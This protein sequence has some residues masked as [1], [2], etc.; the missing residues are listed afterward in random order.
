MIIA[1]SEREMA[2]REAW[3]RTRYETQEKEISD[4]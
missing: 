3:H 1:N 4:D 2:E